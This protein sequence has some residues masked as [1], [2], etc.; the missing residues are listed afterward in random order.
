MTGVSAGVYAYNPQEH[1]LTRT[2]AGDKRLPLCQAALGQRWVRDAAAAI[3]L[4]AVYERTTINYGERG[5][6]YVHME[7]GHA[8]QN[9]SL[10][11]VS[12]DLG[13]VVIGAFHDEEVKAIVGLS[14]QETPLYIIPVGR[15]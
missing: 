7:A 5:I 15:E 13:T 10:Q 9:V 8:A 2:E 12:L 6:R 1:E 14:G 3:V 4:S 11:A